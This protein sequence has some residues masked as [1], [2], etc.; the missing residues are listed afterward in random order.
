MPGSTAQLAGL[1][2]RRAR[3]GIAIPVNAGNKHRLEK[4]RKLRAER[5]TNDLNAPRN[6]G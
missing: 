5:E 4:L 2:V 1:H 3:Q 6:A